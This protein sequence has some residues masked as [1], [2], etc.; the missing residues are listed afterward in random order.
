DHAT[1]TATGR[2]DPIGGPEIH[3]V[4]ELARAYR[5]TRGLRRPIVRFPIPGNTAAAFRTGDATCPEHRV[6]T[7]TWEEWLTECYASEPDNPSVRMKLPP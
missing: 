2:T 3:S 4:G 1:L 6:G 7:V 5:A